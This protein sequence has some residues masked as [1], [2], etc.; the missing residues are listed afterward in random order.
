MFL[1]QFFPHQPKKTEWFYMNNIFFAPLIIFILFYNR[2]KSFFFDPNENLLIFPNIETFL[3]QPFMLSIV[4]PVYNKLNYLNRSLGSILQIQ[5]VSFELIIVDDGSTDGSIDYCMD[6]VRRYPRVTLIRH[7]YNQGLLHSRITGIINARGKYIWNVDS[8]D[9]I[10]PS[11]VPIALKTAIET[12]S[13]ILEFGSTYKHPNGTVIRKRYLKCIQNFTNTD[14]L[15]EEVLNIRVKY[16]IWKKFIKKSI[17]MQAMQLIKGFTYGKRII[18]SEDKILT[19]FLYIFSNNL[20]CTSYKLYSYYYNSQENSQSEIYQK[21]DQIS[22]QDRYADIIY[23]YLIEAK[24]LGKALKLIH[25]HRFFHRR[26]TK[27][28][29]NMLQ[30]ITVIPP[31]FSC[32]FDNTDLVA[33][34]NEENDSCIIRQKI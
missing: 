13:D 3:N 22:Y 34:V 32:S 29:F 28:I 18:N 16:T 1:C 17:Y 25:P 24:S 20:T 19:G 31:T 2:C 26:K 12:N 21:R 27:K 6:L 15:M 4:V 33:Q 5:N 9:G 7:F 11:Q 10:F 23:Q 30:N 8:D 14:E